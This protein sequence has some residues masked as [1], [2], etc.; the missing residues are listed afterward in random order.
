MPFHYKT[1]PCLCS[2]ASRAP[3]RWRH[4]AKPPGGRRGEA[5]RRDRLSALPSPQGV[6]TWR[7]PQPVEADAGGCNARTARTV[8]P[9]RGF[10]GE[11]PGGVGARS[12]ATR[13]PRPGAAARRWG[14]RPGG[15]AT[16]PC[17]FPIRS[18][19]RGGS[20]TRFCAA[21]VRRYPDSKKRTRRSGG[22]SPSWRWPS[23]ASAQSTT[24][25][26]SHCRGS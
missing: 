17:E 25:G 9:R 16:R 26:S 12:N 20:R 10:G 24:P 5:R 19:R 6:S 23:Q 18:G 15:G 2:T 4:T 7:R 11:G 21:S 3:R 8:N 14:A 22:S 1:T 13:A